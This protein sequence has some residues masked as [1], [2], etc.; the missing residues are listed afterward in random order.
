MLAPVTLPG[1]LK[2]YAKHTPSATEVQMGNFWTPPGSFDN[3]ARS[4]IP[5]LA[6]AG[7]R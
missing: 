7:G 5:C 1:H 3:I 2:S 4:G 6:G